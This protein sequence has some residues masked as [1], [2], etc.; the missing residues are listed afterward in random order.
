MNF[1]KMYG[2]RVLVLRPQDPQ[3]AIRLAR[4]CVEADE[5]GRTPEESEAAF[6]AILHAQPYTFIG[7]LGQAYKKIVPVLDKDGKQIDEVRAGD[8]FGSEPDA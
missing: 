8:S 3:L 5:K 4:E 1:Q 6:Q 2:K 7:Y